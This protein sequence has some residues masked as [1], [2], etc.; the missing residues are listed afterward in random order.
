VDNETG[1]AYIYLF[2]IGH[3]FRVAQTGRKFKITELAQFLSDHRLRAVLCFA[4]V[5]SV[6]AGPRALK[7]KDVEAHS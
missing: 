7:V 1:S 2:R 5:T 3:W 4:V 6:R